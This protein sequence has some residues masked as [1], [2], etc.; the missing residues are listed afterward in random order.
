MAETLSRQLEKE[1][2]GKVIPGI[3]IARG[4]KRINHSQFVDDT[5]LLGG[6]S[7]V[8]AKRFQTVLENFTQA[9]GA[10]LNNNK[11]NLYVWNTSL[12]TTRLI[13]N[14]FRFTLI[15]KWKTFKYLGI[16]IC[17]KALP[18]TAWT[19]ILE[20]LK[21]KLE[22][23]GAFWL[24]LAGRTVLIKSILTALPIF[25][26]SSLLAPQNVKAEMSRII[27]RFLWEGGK[28]DNKKFHLISW[29]KI[30]QPRENGGLSIRDPMLVNLSMGAKILWNLVSGKNDW[31]KQ[32]IKKK[33]LL[34]DRLRCLDQINSLSRG[35]P[36]GKLLSASIPLIQKQ[37]TWIPGN[38]RKILIKE[39]SI[40]GKQ[41]LWTHMNLRPLIIW[42]D[43]QG[44]KCIAD[45]SSWNMETGDWIG[46]N[47]TNTPT[48]LQEAA[49]QLQNLLKGCAP[50][51]IN[52]KDKRG[53]G[54]GN[55]TVKQ[56]Y[57]QLLS[58]TNCLPKDK[59]WKAI[60]TNDSPPKVNSFCWI[61]AHGKLLTGENLMKRNMFGPYRCELCGKASDTSQHLFL[62]CPF[63]IIVW[64]TT[65]QNLHERIR[66]P[67]QPKELLINWVSRYQGTSKNPLFKA[68]FN[69]LPKFICWK[70]W[71][72]R[73]RAT[74]A[75]VRTPPEL[76]AKKAVGLMAEFLSTKAKSLLSSPSTSPEFEW[77]SSLHLPPSS[78]PP[79][80][81]QPDP[82]GS[83]TK[84]LIISDG[85]T[86]TR[87]IFSFLT[88][89][90]KAT[91][92]W[93]ERE[94]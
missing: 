63:A 92:G 64:K 55:Y 24:N 29:D 6:A 91:P 90:Q 67:A 18:N 5:L 87:G 35:S 66:W 51:H 17:L 44:K 46:W 80:L 84:R 71:L 65:L 88:E 50:I 2:I 54:N 72:A 62:F 26:F 25:Q 61:L 68:M 11:S 58:Q 36:V 3:K 21:N 86:I 85:A 77:I 32:A 56:G 12:R 20:K 45:I 16:P 59:I 19:H 49:K 23:W 40:M 1:R 27:R 89:P 14:V 74:F 13:A 52:S 39:D 9:S 94:G 28:T 78:T 76:V 10:L 53:W 81:P 43:R 22:Q 69:A 37:L 48:N 42:L 38:G 4:V 70:L 15:E 8:M 30:K 7:I 75:N 47:L 60:W 34:G 83:F 41:P 73:N 31:W 82:T 33:Y 79:P 93:Q 57:A